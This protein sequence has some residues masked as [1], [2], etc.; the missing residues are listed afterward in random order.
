MDNASSHPAHAVKTTPT[1]A[2]WVFILI[3]LSIL[4]VVAK[5]G[6][7]AY[8]E[9]MS[10][11]ISKKNG[12]ELVTWLTEAGTQRFNKGYDHPMC[13]G[14]KAPAK[15]TA[16]DQEGENNDKEDKP[17]EGTWGACFQYLMTQTAFKDMVNPFFNE[18]PKFIP[19]CNP[20]DD[21]LMGAMVLEKMVATPPGSAVPVINSQL[22]DT[23]PIDQKMQL[24]VSVCDKGSYAIKIAEFEF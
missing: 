8:L 5:L 17:T 15:A 12:E 4:S 1:L 13:A 10:T 16:S 14:G 11:E 24:R 23:D 21:T 6:H 20:D 2:D 19:A 7:D 22:V 18:P 9:A 3:V